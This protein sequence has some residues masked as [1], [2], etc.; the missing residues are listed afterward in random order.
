VVIGKKSPS[1]IFVLIIVFDYVGRD[2]AK[3]RVDNA[4]GRRMRARTKRVSRAWSR[5]HDRLT[6]VILQALLKHPVYRY[7]EV[8][9]ALAHARKECIGPQNFAVRIV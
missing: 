6:A 2:R 3:L 8:A 7:Q 9:P 1:F 4:I 5:V